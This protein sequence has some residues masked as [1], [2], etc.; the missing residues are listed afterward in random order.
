MKFFNSLY[1]LIIYIAIILC[2]CNQIVEPDSNVIRFSYS[3]E[4]RTVESD[5]ADTYGTTA[6]IWGYN[7][8][9]YVYGST[10][11]GMEA[12]LNLDDKT[13]SVPSIEG[14]APEYWNSDS[15]HFYSL[16]PPIKN[17]SDGTS[18]GIRF[19]NEPESKGLYF[20]FNTDSQK[21]QLVSYFPISG[22]NAASRIAPVEFEYVHILSKLFF[23][24]QA[25]TANSQDDI[26]LLSFSISNVYFRG[27]CSYN[28]KSTPEWS[29][30]NRDK[31]AIT[32]Y[33]N[34]VT[35][36]TDD[37]EKTSGTLE[38]APLKI[39]STQEGTEVDADGYLIV[40]QTVPWNEIPI[41]FSYGFLNDEGKVYLTKSVKT[42]LPTQKIK[43][44]EQGK[45]Y[46]YYIYLAAESNN[47]V[48]GTPTVSDWETKRT[49][50][51]IIIQ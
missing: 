43:T 31:K 30:S 16:W 12:N 32:L 2:G 20:Y 14:K 24:I 8:N 25:N 42:T 11:L 15:Y 46:R 21:D 9:G 26:A 13:F 35:Y 10:A 3:N 48:F 39:R 29:V 1:Y 18:A 22:N 19:E 36:A 41:E 51:T 37:T 33:Q 17:S 47:I 5:Y 23:N 40:P 7:S 45:V 49:G 38:K 34:N 28:Q 44:W 50:A 4:T 6:T 27:T